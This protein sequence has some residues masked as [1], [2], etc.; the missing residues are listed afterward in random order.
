VAYVHQRD[1]GE[2]LK[3]VLGLAAASLLGVE[4]AGS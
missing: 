4:F 2:M 3:I 1:F